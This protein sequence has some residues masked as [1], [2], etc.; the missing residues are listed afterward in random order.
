[1]PILPA[2]KVRIYIAERV[3]TKIVGPSLYVPILPAEKARIYMA[4]RVRT[5]VGLHL[6]TRLFC[7]QKSQL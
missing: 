7:W 6:S 5:K 4:E 2:E 1:M 3:R